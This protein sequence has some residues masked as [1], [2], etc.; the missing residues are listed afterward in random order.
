MTQA[1]PDLIARYSA[2]VPRYT[3]YP[4]APHFSPAVANLHY[5]D[6]LQELPDGSAL[7][8][9]LHI[10][11]CQRLCWYCGCNTKAVRRYDPVVRYLEA[12]EK[13]VDGVAALVPSRHAVTHIHILSAAHIRQLANKLQT[14]FQVSGGAEFAVEVDPRHLGGPQADAFAEAGV[15]RVS[16]GVQ[17]FDPAVQHA[18][19]R[20]QPL[21]Q[22]HRAIHMFRER[23]VGSVN[24]DLVYGL[25][26]QT[27]DS[28]KQ[29][30]ARVVE[31]AP[32]RVA[33][34]GYAHLPSRFKNQRMIDAAELPGI[35]V[36][37][38]MSELI[39]AL[40]LAAGYVMIGFDHFALPTDPLA[41]R[42]LSRNFQGYTTDR[43]SALI[44]LGASAIGRLKGAY[45]QNATPVADYI[46]RI[47][48]VGLAIARG[49]GLSEDD[50]V[51][52]FAIERLM[53]EMEFSATG[54][55]RQFGAA[56]RPLIAEAEA[57][58]AGDRD[59]LVERAGDGFRVTA[60]GRP[61][62][63]SLCAHFDSYLR[64]GSGQYSVGV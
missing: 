40:L 60:R 63:R 29:T 39:S 3:S 50:R 22:T 12:L 11:Y 28:L 54:L 23:G 41:S 19:N 46:R 52:A 55:E 4:T 56:A 61:F 34:F 43:A 21:E 64:R 1:A 16:I 48:E 62:L 53:C 14:A 27:I 45:V 51:R 24:I 35:N 17:D 42:P 13:E 30:I 6:W 32:E 5:V 44:G 49:L 37:Y 58:V 20:M 26:N 18:I 57:L 10:P 33:A 15:S 9:Y 36:R 47:E 2:P 25:P 59:G 8:L 7:S 38:A 31:L